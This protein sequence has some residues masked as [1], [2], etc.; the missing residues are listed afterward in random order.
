MFK[1]QYEKFKVYEN[2]KKHS[3]EKRQSEVNKSK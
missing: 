2:K 3:F 1:R